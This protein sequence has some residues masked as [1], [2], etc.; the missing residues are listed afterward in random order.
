MTRP[1]PQ[2]TPAQEKRAADWL[3]KQHRGLT[4]V[5]QDELSLWLA[6]APGNQAA[7]RAL[8]RTWREFDQL[9][10]WCPEHAAEPNPD[11]LAGPRRTHFFRWSWALG[12]LALAASLVLAFLLLRP[13]QPPRIRPESGGTITALPAF[14][15]RL[16]PDGSVL[17]LNEG[18]RV[19]TDYSG[20][21]RRVR[22]TQGEMHCLVARDPAHPFIVESAGVEIRALGTSFN[23]RRAKAEVDVVVSSGSVQVATPASVSAPAGDPA[24][25]AAGPTAT[26][27]PVAATVL[28]AGQRARVALDSPQPVVRV[29]TLSSEDLAR[30]LAWMRHFLD[31]SS[32]PLAEVVAEFNRHNSAR[33]RL[34]SDAPGDLPIVA[35]FRAD[36]IDG[37]VRLLELTH[38][39]RVE[40]RASGEI[41]LHGP[42]EGG[43][44]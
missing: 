21:Q 43:S 41:I 28:A 34:A 2:P 22:L 39:W 32:T 38:G 30:T 9:A 26:P 5:E 8:Q 25:L 1:D 11:L 36:N 24:P 19:E 42:P 10:L 15:R 37:F 29:T 20:G 6:A 17:E 4:A 23:V 33:L 13:V 44:P 7:W 3:V 31:F 27:A 14:E 16:L 40:R 18:A 12:S 35:S